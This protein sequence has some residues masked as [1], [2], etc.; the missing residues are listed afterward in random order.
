MK[1]SVVVVTC[2]LAVAVTAW[3][4]KPVTWTHSTEAE[5]ASGKLSKA[6]VTSL[7]EVKLSRALETLVEPAKKNGMISALAIDDRGEVY[8]AAAPKAMVYRLE[9]NKLV[10]FA[11]LPGV[12]VRSMIFTGGELVAGTC[13]KEAGIYRIDRKGKVKKVWTD[14]KVASVWSVLPG[15]GGSFYAATGAEGKIY[16]VKPNGKAEVIYDSDEKNILSLTRDKTGLLYA[17]T[18]EDGLI[19]EVDPKH[20]KGRILYDAKEA[21]ISCL[22]VDAD[23]VLY[24]A[25]SDSSKASADGEKPSGEIKGK[26]DKTTT[27][28]AT[29]PA[30]KTPVTTSPA[31]QIDKKSLELESLKKLLV[32]PDSKSVEPTNKFSERVK[33]VKFIRTKDGK[34]MLVG[35][36]GTTKKKSAPTPRQVPPEIMRRIAAA[37]RSSA[38]RRST[39]SK[40]PSGKGNA[41]Y[42]IDKAGFV[43]AVFRRPVTILAMVMHE[44][45][46]VLG[47]GHGGQ[48]FTVETDGEQIC[49][50]AKLD[51]KDVT[52]LVADAKGRLYI[53][54]A[55]AG[56]LF[57]LGK[58]FAVK[59]TCISKV[60]DAKQIA[61]WGTMNVRADVPAGCGVTVA[62]RSG[63]VAKPDEKTWSDWSVETIVAPGWFPITCPAGRFI[64]YR[65]TLA[66]EGQAT[67]A[68]DKVALVHQ[69]G[70]LAPA[71]SAVQVSASSK[72]VPGKGSASPMRYRI[73][74]AKASDPNGDA[75]QYAVFFRRIGRK[76]WVE[77]VEKSSKPVYAWDTL[78]VPDGDY[79]IRVEVS[80][81]PGN[82]PSAALTAARISRPIIVDNSPPKATGLV[83]KNLG[84]GKVSLSGKAG[85]A[86]SRIRRIDYAVDSNEEWVRLLPADGICDS[87]RETFSTVIS[88]LKPGM[89][90]IAVRVTDQYNNTGYASAEITVGK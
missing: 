34:L 83:V 19:I 39:P 49:A 10:E 74:K 87:Q 9:G 51:P 46:L 67:P 14:K 11:Q 7:G 53:G 22:L 61:Q 28:P 82:A 89:H 40:P 43:L 59:G 4:V 20:K 70:N 63:N 73:I 60:F 5:F 31:K 15:P 42:R 79:E 3:A 54:T 2:V 58:G 37:R 29:K 44:G 78:A 35:T 85:D 41:V 32:K 86:I 72:P 33:Q 48:V 62:A 26:P 23:G 18:G 90:R 21:E 75:V 69:V 55:G 52:A 36:G 25:T 27:R 8:L 45:V 13:G 76:K 50:I 12:L 16:H 17:G 1:K 64:Q 66:G 24:A 81:A 6:V 47:T 77:L 57:T 71:V 80:D 84:K 88:D 65:L 38:A 68:V 30:K 56:G